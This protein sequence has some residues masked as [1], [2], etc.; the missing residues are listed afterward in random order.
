MTSLTLMFALKLPLQPL[1]LTRR[2]G[3]VEAV[4]LSCQGCK[5]AG[6]AGIIRF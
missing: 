6:E 2:S 3:S 1:N 5:A 4:R